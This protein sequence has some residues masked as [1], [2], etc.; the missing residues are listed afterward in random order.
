MPKLRLTPPEEALEE[1][2]PREVPVRYSSVR[3][4]RLVRRLAL[5]GGAATL[6]VAASVVPATASASLP[7]TKAV[8]FIDSQQRSDGGFGQ[9]EAG[10]PGFE[11]PDAVIAIGA[12]AS[13]ENGGGWD[14]VRA[15]DA[16]AGQTTKGHSGLHY[17]D[18]WADGKLGALGAGGAARITIVAEALGF[19]PA[20]FDP[21]CDGATN[22][23]AT[24]LAGEKS[25]G[26][27]GAGALNTTLTAAIALHVAGHA[28]DA[29]TVA[30]IEAAQQANGSW[31]FAGDPSKT[32]LDPDT[33]GL[34]IQALV[35]AGVPVSNASIAHALAFLASSQNADGSWSDA[36]ANQPNPN[37]TALSMFGLGAVGIDTSTRA[38]RDQYDPS[39]AGQPYS[40]P[41]SAIL[42]TQQTDGRFASPN[43]SFGINTFATA[44]G[45]EALTGFQPVS[46]T[47]TATCATPP[48]TTTTR[49]T[50]TTS[51][52]TST[53]AGSV[54]GQGST[55]TTSSGDGTG[56]LP[57][58][59]S[60]SGLGAVVAIACIALGAAFLRAGRR[61]AFGTQ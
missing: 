61:R 47:P 53:T 52:A 38:W 22:L 7:L 14:P 4:A 6:S 45:V 28:V 56:T 10:F 55:T 46:S 29:S 43:D 59:G 36:F 57:R 49:P 2:G 15:R 16:V 11:T 26:T 33:T 21:D 24:V 9:G 3:L 17:L 25:D 37:S 41:S 60:G 27:W 50:T 8:G 35:A 30:A 51:S 18:D 1:R 19:D 31:N 39:R 58:T 44:Q 13:T 48:S 20:K 32:D 23:V 34:A 5:V 12:V 40:A 42:A 54:S